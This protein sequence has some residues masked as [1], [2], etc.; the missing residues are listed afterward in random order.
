MP[1][2]AWGE[3]YQPLAFGGKNEEKN[4]ESMEKGGNVKIRHRRKISKMAKCGK[5]R[6]TLA[7]KV[8]GGLH[9]HS[10]RGIISGGDRKGGSGF[11]I[12]NRP[13][14]VGG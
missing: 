11:S 3:R 12:K 8:Q 2:Q 10:E 4:R 7:K 9:K 14:A 1:P 5:N 13:L 6:E